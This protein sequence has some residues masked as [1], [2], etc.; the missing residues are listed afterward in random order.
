MYAHPPG[1]KTSVIGLQVHPEGVW[2]RRGGGTHVGLRH[3]RAGARRQRLPDR[4]DHQARGRQRHH[5]G[6]RHM[7]Q[8]VGRREWGRAIGPGQELGLRGRRARHGAMQP[9]GFRSARGH[10]RLRSS[11]CGGVHRATCAAQQRRGPSSCCCAAEAGN[12]LCSGVRHEESMR[13]HCAACVHHGTC[14][15]HGWAS[16]S[17]C[18]LACWCSGVQ[19]YEETAGLTVGDVV[20]RTKK[21]GGGWRKSTIWFSEHLKLGSTLMLT[22]AWHSPG[23]GQAAFGD[24]AGAQVA[25]R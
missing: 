11:T 22:H 19:V 20:T 15:E 21:V 3:V 25:R 5:P 23:L 24:S 14:Y 1:P 12:G 16:Y 2:A 8:A 17:T 4:R 18:H 6:E 9:Q 7:L 13:S 10:E